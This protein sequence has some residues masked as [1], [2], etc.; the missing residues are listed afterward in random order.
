MTHGTLATHYSR[1]SDVIGSYPGRGRVVVELR[2]RSAPI[3]E[4]LAF[5]KSFT[6]SRDLSKIC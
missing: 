2:C 1:K 5:S 6:G 4:I 3:K